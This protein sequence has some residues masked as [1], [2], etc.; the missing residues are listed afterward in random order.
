MLEVTSLS[1]I[2]FS[3]QNFMFYEAIV[4]GTFFSYLL[5]SLSVCLLLVDR[6]VSGFSMLILILYPD[7]LLKI[8]IKF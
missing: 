4:D 8:W 6:N 1:L 2:K 3:S 7:I 5:I